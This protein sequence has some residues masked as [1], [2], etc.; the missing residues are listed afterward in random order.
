M[1]LVYAAQIAAKRRIHS[2]LTYF[3][4]SFEIVLISPY[5]PLICQQKKKGGDMG[6][7]L[8]LL[9]VEKI[10]DE[11]RYNYFGRDTNEEDHFFNAAINLD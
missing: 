10:I 11:L 6:F 8:V 4:L 1:L 2:E 5:Y 3:L 7:E 9:C